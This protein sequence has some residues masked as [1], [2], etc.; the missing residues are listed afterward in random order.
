L[1]VGVYRTRPDTWT[2]D[3]LLFADRYFYIPRVLFAWLLIWEL[4]AIPRA[5]AIVARLACLLAVVV[6]L[7]DYQI[8]APPDYHW[9]EHVDPIRRGVPAEIPT[10]PAGWSME[11][12]GRPRGNANVR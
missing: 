6:H 2:S 7:R 11:Y 3:N 9:A 10:L 12:H 5:I 8:A 1:L 4:D